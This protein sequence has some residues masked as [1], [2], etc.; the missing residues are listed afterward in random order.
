MDVPTANYALPLL[1]AGA[2]LAGV[3]VG[4]WLGRRS[5]A[6]VESTRRLAAAEVVA[7]REAERRRELEA[8]VEEQESALRDLDR[9]LAVAQ[10]RSASLEEARRDIE[11]TFEALAHRALKGNAEQ[12]LALAH[13]SLR[14]HQSE[15]DRTA[16]ARER[17]IA[18]LVRP[19]GEQLAKLDHR[20]ADLERARTEAYSRL[21]E[22]VRH[23]ARLTEGLR[24]DTTS[25]A[26]ALKGSETRGRWGEIALRNVVELAGMTRHCDYVE[27]TTTDDGGRPDM[28]VHLPG[29]RHIAV[30]AKTPLSAYLEAQDAPDSRARRKAYRRHARSVRDHVKKLSAREYAKAIPG[31]VDLVVLFLPGDPFL[32]AAFEHD[33]DLQV[34]ALRRKVL[35][36][37]PTTLVALL[38]TVAIYWQQSAMVENAEAIASTARELYERTAKFGE[39]LAQMGK[40]LAGALDAYNRAV[41][42]FDRRLT[43]MGRKLEDS[44]LAGDQTRRRLSAPAAIEDPVR[45]STHGQPEAT[46]EAGDADEIEDSGPRRLPFDIG[47]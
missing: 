36:A 33:P 46:A 27:Q 24:G 11:T 5:G 23:L 45:Q 16:D 12:F 10:E 20:T 40:G 22:Q 31:D 21:G 8:E 29:G 28:I 3:A 14:V 39:D 13:E 35:V 41:G 15:S 47:S 2:A 44:G 43:P 4:W 19:L 6:S 1:L 25:L 26:S 38:R 18:E 9:R 32:S 42:S 30:D 37:T 17:A 7:E 34:D